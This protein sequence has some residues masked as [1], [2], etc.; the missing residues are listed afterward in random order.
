LELTVE[1]DC[2]NIVYTKQVG[3]FTDNVKMDPVTLMVNEHDY[4]S[5][6]GIALQCD[7]TPL[8]SG[9]VKVHTGFNN[10]IFSDSGC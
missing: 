5:I 9:Y 10:F 6:S 4:A 3:P 1:N 8:A 2:G 7:G